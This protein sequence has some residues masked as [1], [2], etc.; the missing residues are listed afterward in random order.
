MQKQMCELGLCL[1]VWDSSGDPVGACAPKCDFCRTIKG[2]NGGCMEQLKK[3]AGRVIAETQPV[4]D[5]LQW[6]CCG[7]GV[8]IFQRR[9]LMGA[10]VAC[11][12]PVEMVEEGR[13]PEL[14]SRLNLDAKKIEEFFHLCSRHSA[15]EANDFLHMLEWLLNREQ[16][17]AT[18]QNELSNLSTN[19]TT[20]YEELS[21]LYSIS[22][23][24]KVTQK[25]ED[26]LLN[27]CQELKEVMDI[28]AAC[29]VLYA[30]P[31][32]LQDDVLVVS[33]EVDLNAAQIKLLTATQ[34]APQFE[35]THHAFVDNNFQAPPESGLGR[36]VSNLVAVPLVVE[37]SLIGVLVGVNKIA[38]EFDSIDMK[39]INSIGNQ[40]T[41][42]LHNN[43]LYADLQDL[44]MGVLHAL[45]S[46]IDA[47][48]PYT[49]GHSQR[50]ALISRKLAEAFGFNRERV[51]Q[52]YL[53]GLLHDIGKI[54]V[55]ESIL[56]KP[57][58]LTEEEYEQIKKHPARG[59]K[60]LEGIR[61]LDHIIGGI[62]T[63]HERLDGRG[64]PQ[65]LKGD[66]VPIEGRIVGL[67]D[68]FDAMTSDRTYRKALSLDR[69]IQEIREHSG[70][71]FDPDVVEKFLSMDME[72]LMEELQKPVKA[73]VSGNLFQ[74]AGK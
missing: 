63:H 3:L 59:A 7:L 37:D 8:P 70:T 56:C 40:T 55:P 25:P 49:S 74:E 6:G 15:S 35:K 73:T 54:G 43:H 34:I 41:V 23:S 68:C 5:R 29:A 67:A 14:C 19:L 38:G 4:S 58:R 69:V 39:L 52:I 50:V 24:M 48:D 22:G 71:Q 21:L 42:F 2:A 46:S 45:T 36:A 44:L 26:F 10:A 72:K 64:Y 65:G 53:A 27:V 13:I 31:P 47:K 66:E 28:A 30:H 33:G 1:S 57:G 12:H 9:R 11:F 62:L 17:V 61:Q 18:A 16:A 60:I 51:Q 32:A 20:T